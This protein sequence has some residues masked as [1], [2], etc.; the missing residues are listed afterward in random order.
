[1]VSSL[2]GPPSS[3]GDDPSSRVRAVPGDG[4]VISAPRAPAPPPTGSTDEIGRTLEGHSLGPYVLE[5]FV[6]GGG[7]G[8]VFRAVDT[9]LDRVVAVKVLS[10][11]QSSDA[12]TLRRFKNEAQLAARLDH[13][14]IGRVHNVGSEGGWHFIVFEYIEGTNL[15]D[16]VLAGGPLD[17]GRTI[18]FTAQI[19]EAL[20]HASARGVV[21]RDIKPSNIIVTPAGRARLVDM[22]LARLPTMEGVPDLTA[23]GMTLGTF[24]YISP[25]Q[26]RDPRAA[27]VR[28]DLYSL[29]CTTFFMLTARPPF[30]E[31]TLVQKLLQHQQSTPPAVGEERPDV[32]PQLEAI[33]SR[34]LEKRPEDRY[35]RAA[36]LVADLEAL[37]ADLGID[38]GIDLEV[39]GGTVGPA[40]AF[41]R[42]ER[43]SP[44]PW[45]VPVAALAALVAGLWVMP[46]LRA[47]FRPASPAPLPASLASSGADVPAVPAATRRT[48]RVGAGTDATGSLAEAWE[49]AGDGDVVECAF[50]GDRDCPPLELGGGKRL[51]LRAA[52]GHDP[53]LRVPADPP[54]ATGAAGAERGTIVV[55]S[56][57][58]V[59]ERLG[60]RVK[61]GAP[62]PFFLSGGAG[63]E[64]RAVTIEREGGDRPGA[65]DAEATLVRVGP[66]RTGPAP[67]RLR[68]EAT[69]AVGEGTFLSLEPSADVALEWTGGGCGVGGHFLRASG[70]P[71]GASGT[72]ATVV[73]EEATIA[74]G[75]GFASLVDSAATPTIPSL[76]LRARRCRFVIEPGG[77]FVEQAGIGSPEAYRAAV[78]WSDEDARYEG[79]E[80]FRRIDGAAEREEL[81]FPTGDGRQASA[82]GGGRDVL[83]RKGAAG[84]PRPGFPPL[85]AVP[86]L[87][88][89]GGAIV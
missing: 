73:L 71:R 14:N 10:R 5:R 19:A 80:T 58:L 77:V 11:Q 89:G 83:S 72:R 56:G 74:A 23:S 85:S 44:W 67:S 36:D 17:V 18:R 84:A 46:A 49:A 52:D 64:L 63:L 70:A 4:T 62:A 21:H 43:R 2:S 42:R 32:P 27:D 59:V 20:E 33:V 3:P 30:A 16:T 40:P 78:R 38:L 69:S 1:M 12:D 53:V 50:D 34:L 6:G 57:T 54:G 68:C 13:E 48:W 37:A 82:E 45:A 76:E 55:A 26:A 22:G 51:T 41:R 35:Q 86:L 25:E 15:R 47:R 8:A 87:D 31:G 65:S 60:F 9:T 79:G 75:S 81:P 28:S 88:T 39:G 29:G 61:A 7:M 24:D 66:A